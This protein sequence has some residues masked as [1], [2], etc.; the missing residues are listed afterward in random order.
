MQRNQDSPVNESRNPRGC[1][2]QRV[3]DAKPDTVLRCGILLWWREEDLETGSKGF[4]M[5]AMVGI[6]QM[7]EGPSL[8]MWLAEFE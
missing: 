6:V 4:V 1:I 3:E 7:H 5:T 8:Q 2:D